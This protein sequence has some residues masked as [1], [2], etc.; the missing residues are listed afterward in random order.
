MPKHKQKKVHHAFG[1]WSLL[2]T[3]TGLSAFYLLAFRPWH[4][5]WGASE[6][7]TA[8]AL[9]SDDMVSQPKMH[10][11]HAITIHAP[12]KEVWAWL[13]QIGQGR[14]G[15]Y[16]YTWIENLMGSG[17][18][19][20]ERILPEYQNLKVGDVVPF[21]KNGLG[22]PVA[23]VDPYKTLVLHGDTRHG[24]ELEMGYM[25]FSWAFHLEEVDAN[26]TRLIERMRGDWQPSLPLMA[27]KYLLYELGTFI[28][29]QKMLRG[30]KERAEKA[31]L[32]QRL[33]S[34]EERLARVV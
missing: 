33:G 30:I 29:E 28:M 1:W 18:H 27:D 20:A 31:A 25:N 2:K 24:D 32:E 26:T 13:V 7:E 8:R 21:T 22:M 5:K 6:E 19:N 23:Q 4:L 15:F 9:P 3:V 12:A 17:I 10:A 34:K 16:S 14:G 11:T